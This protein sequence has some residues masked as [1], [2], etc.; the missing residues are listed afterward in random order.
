MVSP[1]NAIAHVSGVVE[2]VNPGGTGA[3]A[4]V[5]R[6][7]D[8][9]LL[10][11]GSGR[12]AAEPVLTNHVAEYVALGRALQAYIALRLPGPLLVRGDSRLLI[13]QMRG[14]WQ[15]R[16]GAYVRAHRSVADL[17]L[18][19]PFEVQ[20]EWVPQTQNE[21]V[22]EMTRAALAGSASC[23]VHVP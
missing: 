6:S 20:W 13:R 15:V 4:F 12:I 9:I 10:R 21:R 16:R 18:R 3:W 1:P 11:E 19:C 2:P 7:F 8:G 17:L 5:I 22:Y 14:E 23:P